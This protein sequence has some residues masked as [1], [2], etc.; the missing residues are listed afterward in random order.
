MDFLRFLVEQCDFIS[1]ACGAVSSTRI[2]AVQ[3]SLMKNALQQI[4]DRIV[5]SR[6]M[7][8]R[9]V[10]PFQRPAWF[11]D[12]ISEKEREDGSLNIRAE[13]EVFRRE[14]TVFLRQVICQ[15]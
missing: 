8:S 15:L 9:N 12:A 5:T 11:V 1:G 2:K 7:D 14:K 6:C 13:F 3:G 10:V 4:L